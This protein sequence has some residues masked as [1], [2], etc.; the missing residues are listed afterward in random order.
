M[1]PEPREEDISLLVHRLSTPLKGDMAK[2]IKENGAW[3][4]LIS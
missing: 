4:V 2:W 1:L 3:L